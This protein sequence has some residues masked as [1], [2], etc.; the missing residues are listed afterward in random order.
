MDFMGYLRPK[1]VF[2]STALIDS[3]TNL[4][5]NYGS[6]L[7]NLDDIEVLAQLIN[8]SWPR[9]WTVTANLSSIYRQ[10]SLAAILKPAIIQVG[11]TFILMS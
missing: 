1:M 6:A 2:C 3:T 9:L 8:A 4:A 7:I 10:D 11:W 5:K